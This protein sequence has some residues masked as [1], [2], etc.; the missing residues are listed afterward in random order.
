M[1]TD[2]ARTPAPSALYARRSRRIVVP[3]PGRG[4]VVLDAGAGV[5]SAAS[6]TRP[7]EGG[8]SWIRRGGPFL[9]DPRLRRLQDLRGRSVFSLLDSTSLVWKSSEDIIFPKEFGFVLV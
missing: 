8:D 7:A 3:V 5:P 9:P 1:F 4:A 2:P 6:R